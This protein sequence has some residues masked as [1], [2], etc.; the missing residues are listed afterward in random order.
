MR[1]IIKNRK[2]YKPLLWVPYNIFLDISIFDD[3]SLIKSE[4]F[5]KKNKLFINK[6]NDLNHYIELNGV[7]L[8]TV[9]FS[10]IIDN[11]K[12]FNVDLDTLTRRNE[13]LL[14]PVPVDAFSIKILSKV[15]IYP[16]ENISLEGLY[17]SNEMFCTQ[18]E[19]EGFR[20][21]TWFTDRPDCLATFKVRIEGS[22][23]YST[24]L[25][26]GNLIEA[27]N[28][29]VE[30]EKTDRHFAIWSDPFPKPSYLFAL[31]VGNLEVSESSF[32]TS[33]NKNIELK[34]FTEIG[35]KHLTTHAMKSLKK[36]MAW[37]EKKYGLEY[38]LK[39]FMIVAVSHFNMGAM[40][41]KGLNIFNSKFVLA[42]DS[43]ATDTDL[44]NIESI[45]AHEYFH[46]W[47]G[48]RVTCRDWFQLTLK[49]GLTVFRDQEFSA[50]MNDKDVKRI[51]DV[52]LLKSIQFPEDAGS[53]SH[54]IRPDEYI[55]INNFYTPTIYEKGAEVIRMIVNYIGEENYRNGMNAYFR[56]YDGQAITCED[57]LKALTL[58]SNISLDLFKKWYNQSGTPNVNIIRTKNKYDWNFN[59]SQSINNQPSDLPIPIKISLIDKNG[60]LIKFKIDNSEL[61]IE[62]VYLLSK[63]NDNIKISSETLE[64]TPSLLRNFSAPVI[65]KTDLVINDY[66]HI[67]KFDNDGFN[68]WD[69]IQNLYLDSYLN[70]NNL[71]SITLVLRDLLSKKIINFSLL[72]FLLDI[73]SRGAFEHFLNISNP[74]QI[75]KKRKELMK[76]I[77]VALQDI[78][79]IKALELFNYK[80]NADKKNGERALLDK[81][82]NYL[83]LINNK[84]GVDL[85]KKISLSKNMTISI[86]GLKSLCLYG[87]EPPLDLLNKFFIKWKDHS[88]VIE[89]WFE[90]MSS[91]NIEGKGL[92]FIKDLLSHES[93]EYKNPNKIRSV[94]GAFQKENVLLFHA[95]DSSGYDFISEQVSLIDE[96]N[97][98]VAARLVLPLT[99]FSN[100]DEFRKNKMK[101]ALKNIFNQPISKDLS[102]IVTKALR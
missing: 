27:G 68:K 26:N 1:S 37:D 20:K 5:F 79:E 69:A 51:E 15:K 59:I 33:S 14:L 22:N 76:I 56:L 7:N 82:L 77:G 91:L 74:I 52:L 36:A 34:I 55:E 32:I 85:A 9:Y 18:C 25:S 70:N 44:G 96:N 30:G 65:L 24:M 67:L 86:T 57:F 35:N 84:A 31:I 3:F 53:N 66:L 47:T 95:N 98:Q 63:S 43:T 10:V 8:E 80:I 42:D 17:E 45:V 21:I 49:E 12:P 41:N 54:S 38:D 48:N 6:K 87:S 4:I 101:K 16:K 39:T 2:D 46:N 19:P 93:F 75:F 99:R 60:S 97:P 72:S 90:L 102:E 58:G 40:E 28:V 89:K 78:F 29:K 11:D 92:N 13:V 83:V 23:F 81:I 50:D 88:L 94:L 62:H 100:Y 61:N 64:A 73:P 71:Y